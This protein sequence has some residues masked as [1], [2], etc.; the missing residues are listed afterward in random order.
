MHDKADR[1]AAMQRVGRIGHFL[2]MVCMLLYNSDI[3]T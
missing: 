2:A 1:R 3:P